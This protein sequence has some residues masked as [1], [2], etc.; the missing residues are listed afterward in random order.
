MPNFSIPDHVFE[1]AARQFP[2]PF[3]LY[4]EKGIREGIR[5]VRQAFSWAPR[6][7]EYFAVKAL[8]NP[9]ILQLFIDEGFGLDCA[10]RCELLMAEKTGAQG[11]IMFSANDVPAGEFAQAH[12]LGAILNLDDITD[13]DQMA[14]ECGV[15]EVVS[16]RFNPGGTLS[17][18]NQIM[19]NPG[20]NKYGWT[21]PQLT[22]GLTRLKRMGV[23][24]FGLHAL[25]ASNTQDN[26]YYPA[27]A[28][29]LMET[30][31][32]V[33]RETGLPVDFINL[34]GGVGIAY[35]P[36]DAMPD[37]EAIGQGVRAAYEDVFGAPT[38][39]NVAI[40]CEMGR[41]MTGPYGWLVTR[42]IHH[43]DTYR[44]YIGVDACTGN[45]PRP[46]IYG[47][48]HHVSVVGKRDLPHDR[49]CDVVGA[50]CENTDKFA[51]QRPLPPIEKGDLLLVHDAGAHCFAMG[52]NYNGRLACAEVLLR[53][54]GTFQQIRRAQTPED[55][56]A[57]LL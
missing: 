26:T 53:E 36:G 19:G 7:M 13:I 40:C 54:N 30:A 55:Y 24:R 35:R 29:L 2:T 45:L 4:D 57:T 56:F 23:K 33:S 38:Q 3:Y 12:A 25:L 49:I 27:L 11:R 37:I 32:E 34:S 5:R 10:S 21:R 50:M 15:P 39:D 47:A 14:A 41:F 52:H 18:A 20:E 31:A 17:V 28:R 1:A 8:P 6:F 9:R 46:A 44:H 48:Y 42:A 16:V 43:K 51:V 22:E